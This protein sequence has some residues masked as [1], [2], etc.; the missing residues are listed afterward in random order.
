[1]SLTNKYLKYSP[2]ITLEIFTLVCNKLIDNGWELYNNQSIECIWEY[3]SVKNWLGIKD[4]NNRIIQYKNNLPE[5]FTE[6]TVQE[7]LGYDPFVKDDFV[8]PQKWYIKCTPESKDALDKWTGF[9]WIYNYIY[10]DGKNRSHSMKYNDN[11][12]TEITFDQF[13]KYV[14][15]E[16]V[17]EPKEIIPEY[18]KCISLYESK[19]QG[20][21][22]YFTIGKIYKLSAKPSDKF[23]YIFGDDN[24]EWACDFN[25]FKPSTKE[26]FD[27]QNNPKP[28]EKWSV[29]SYFV[30]EE[31]R[32]YN[33][34]CAK[35]GD[36][37][38]IRTNGT[39]NFID[40]RDTINWSFYSKEGS[41]WFATLPE[42]EEYA[43]T[44]IEPIKEE[45]K[46]P[47]KQAVHCKTQEEWDFVAKK[48]N[49]T[50]DWEE[51]YPCQI[52]IGESNWKGGIEFCINENIE[53]LSFQEW[54]SLSNY[55]MDKKKYTIKELETNDKLIIYLDSK[56]EW[57]KLRKYTTK[58]TS[59]YHGKHCYS[60][61]D[62]TYSSD[63]SRICFGG[64]NSDSII[65]TIDDIIFEDDKVEV[66]SEVKPDPEFKVGDWVIG[67]HHNDSYFHKIPW[68]IS[69][70]SECGIRVYQE[71]EGIWY[72][73]KSNIR[74]ATPEEVIQYLT[75]IGTQ[76][77]VPMIED[78]SKN[79]MILSIDDEEL[80]MVS[81]I[82]TST[83]KQL[84]NN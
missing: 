65:L 74:H 82:K 75:S 12:Y 83:I 56:E 15:K 17:E 22:D 25:Q 14:L 55:I 21:S 48:I 20:W 64:Y 42:A 52:L 28:I 71:G 27:A 37:C 6:T 1:M 59:Q 70:I 32:L 51:E 44:L 66:K 50:N 38:I 4:D 30:I 2:K 43:K 26:A 47:L 39:F 62:G 77:L 49:R 54:C 18:V 68:K 79:K 61:I 60:C 72:T 8:L 11:Y 19:I 31:D 81:V 36:I 40:K 53:L 16:T 58:S 29:G 63:S 46:Q 80:P 57:I 7:I 5:N 84:I 24:E 10:F 78:N 33:I 13:K 73:S 76:E 69:K 34:S 23:T 35:R 9:T 67:W 45:V 41:K 3:L